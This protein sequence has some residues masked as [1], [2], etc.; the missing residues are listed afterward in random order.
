[1]TGKLAQR[2]HHLKAA[3]T[4]STSFDAMNHEMVRKVFGGG[5][6]HSGKM[7]TEDS[8]MGISAA[9][10][11][12]R[13][14]SETIGTV[15]WALY[16][17]TEDGNAEKVDDHELSDCLVHSP[18]AHMTSVELKEA[19]ALNLCQAGNSYCKISRSGPRITALTPVRAPLVQPVLRK[20]GSVIYKITEN[21]VPV[22]H[23][24]RDIWHVKGFG[25]NG[26]IGLSPL[27]AA[28]ESMGF[29]MATEEFGA[30]FFAQGGAPSGIVTV[31]NFL[32]DEQR[33]IAREN[34]QQMMGGLGNAHKFA[35]FE[36]GLKPEPW[37]DMPL[38]D[39][40]FLLLRQFSVQEMSRFYRVPP[41]MVA[42][43]A[44]ATFSN[45]EQQSQEFVMYSLMP[46]FTR[47]E[48]SASKWLLSVED[49]RKYFLRFNFE[50]LLRADSAARVAFYNGALQNGWMSRN[51]VRAKE[52]L[53]KVDGLDDYT[54]QINMS[55]IEDLG[56][57]L[58]AT[59]G[60]V[61]PLNEQE[62]EDGKKSFS[63]GI[64]VT[65]GPHF[66]L[67]VQPESM[68]VLTKAITDSARALNTSTMAV[69]KST[70]EAMRK[71]SEESARLS[72]EASARNESALKESTQT[73]A[74]ASALA[75][76]RNENAL[77]ETTQIVIKA[78]LAASERGE[79]FAQESAQAIVDATVLASD[80]SEQVL[81]ELARI[82]ASPRKAVFDP[83]TGE[84]IGSAIAEIAP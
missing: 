54:V 48:A 33:K 65:T 55:K 12:M 23:S 8:A 13:V 77:K 21:G 40:Q 79:A 45:I 62:Q 18:N 3:V 63:G 69:A 2:W 46:Y 60:G 70:Q 5:P 68:A 47:I 30:K 78:T 44:R 53:N 39:M 51:E 9:W 49:R 6:T 41:H 29:A 80:R 38:D 7:V 74:E 20:D 4:G 27:G 34:L 32:K 52:N 28:R 26:L 83:K 43:L 84:P 82:S 64:S 73:L 24:Q 14:L 59:V 10:G 50:G 71:T 11:C 37:A 72:R 17:R 25:N 16:R 42:D 75:A 36:G 31:P 58:P 35:L 15:P 57:Q 1:M 76:E 81:R 66:D 56:K 61:A 19:I 22:E 67:N